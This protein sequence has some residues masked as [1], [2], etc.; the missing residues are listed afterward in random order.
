MNKQQ[1]PLIIHAIANFMTGGS[2]QLV[3]DLVRGLGAIYDQEVL[4]SYSPHPPAYQGV[5]ISE[6]N[7]SC[8]VNNLVEYFTKL[9][10]MIVHVHYWGECDYQWYHKVFLAAQQVGCK[11]IENINTPVE[12]YVAG[13]ISRYVYVS[14]YVLKNFTS[15]YPHKSVVIYP[16]S[17]FKFFQRTNSQLPDDCIGMV[18]RLE[19]DKL[20]ESA[21]DVFIKV[22][23]K[24]P[25]TKILIVG[26]G[27]FLDVY[28][29]AVTR[30]SVKENFVFTG[31]VPYQELPALYARM[32]MFVAPVWKE[33]FGQVSPFAMS[34]GIPVVGYDIGAINEIISDKSL[35]AEPGNS[36]MLSDIICNLLDDKKR[37]LIIGDFN[38]ER[39]LRNFSVEAMIASYAKL[40]DEVLSESKHGVPLIEKRN[41][42]KRVVLFVHCF[43]PEHFYGTEVYTYKLA[44]N[45]KKHN[46]EPIIVSAKF[47][48]TSRANNFISYYEYEGLPVYCIDKNYMPNRRVKDTYYQEEM[49]SVLETI[50]EE[51]Q[52]DLVHVTHIIN[53]TAVLF[54]VLEKLNIP[55]VITMTDFFGHCLNN[56][57]QAADGTMCS[58]PNSTRINCLLCLHLARI[59]SGTAVKLE[60]FII[61]YPWLASFEWLAGKVLKSSQAKRVVD[62]LIGFGNNVIVDN[63][64]DVI[65]RPEILSKCYDKL[66][67]AI[68]PTKF[69]YRMYRE[70][71]LNIPMHR[72]P[73]GVD[74]VSKD[75]VTKT[76]CNHLRIGYIGQI[77]YHKGIDV[78]ITAFFAAERSNKAEVYIYGSEAQAPNY[79]KELRRLA[80]GKA[81]HF[82]GTFPQEQTESVLSE[83]DVLVIPS[84]WYENSPLILLLA[85]ASHT[86]VI[87]SNVEG[88]TEFIV[89]GE[90][91][92]IFNI[93]DS[94]QLC[95]ILVKI[96]DNPQIIYNMQITTNYDRDSELMTLETIQVYNQLLDEG[97]AG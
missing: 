85:L 13:S 93:N 6:Y 31:Y 90:N 82:M 76:M 74:I 25:Q 20:N 33:S 68:V 61:R 53:H 1:K 48:G 15:G 5:K 58:G 40:Y 91:G 97:E 35:V 70:N 88:M 14:Q 44:Q 54:E 59:H 43:F 87:V 26:G 92:F 50:L 95:N 73:F 7:Y 36:D 51:L 45:L 55:R 77:D 12:P 69:T 19:N 79:A 38:R 86:P 63:I 75:K 37:R 21:I 42:R 66:Q 29:N 17:D 49:R 34:F 67:A 23:Q 46:F 62:K 80:D 94:V 81:I 32:S 60:S 3:M 10:P 78:L 57:L 27:T 71:G 64:N 18:Y 16:G 47:Q 11:I 22:A 9:K 4:T 89:D 96:I 2:S 84:R 41:D 52:P 24:R 56:K 28:K 72:I 83:I 65:Q 39:A 30:A 8:S